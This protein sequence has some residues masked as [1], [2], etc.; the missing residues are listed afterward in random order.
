MREVGAQVD[1]GGQRRR[2]LRLQRQAGRVEAAA[3]RQ[4]HVA[5]LERI[6]AGG[7][8]GCCFV[9]VAQAGA[10]HVDAALAEHPVEQRRVGV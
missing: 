8:A 3:Q 7:G 9:E 5:E 6:R 1:A 4:L 2:R 10:A